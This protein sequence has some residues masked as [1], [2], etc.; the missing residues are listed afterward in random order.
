MPK[1]SFALEA[2]GEKRLEISW[3][4]IYKDV[5]VSVDGNSIG[6]IPNQKAL[7]AGQE[8]R[9]IDGSTIKVQ[10]VSKFMSTELQV[11][12]NGQPLPGSASD[13]QTKV[14]NA[15]GMVYFVAGLNLVL[16][17]VSFLFNVEFLQQIGIGFGSILFGL[18]FL[19]LGFFVQRKS[20]VALILAIVIFALDGIVGF[21]LAASQGYNPGGGGIVARIFLLIPM[22]QGC[23]SQT[24]KVYPASGKER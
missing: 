3:K 2:G 9:S 24:A 6:V 15:Y 17:L 20:T 4:G 16:G 13:P 23:I 11:L 7:S 14:K 5:T 21:F 12:C 22:I 19:A 8:F 18:V 1:Q 10:L